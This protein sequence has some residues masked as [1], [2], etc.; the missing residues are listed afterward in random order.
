MSLNLTLLL[1][2]GVLYSVGI[3]LV[4]ER[5]L[6]RVLLGIMLLTNGTNLL[7]LHAG[8]LPGRSPLYDSGLDPRAYSDPLPQALVLTAIVI[9]FGLTAF[10]LGMIYRSWVLSHRD[11]ITD[12][13]ED[14]RVATQSSYDEELDADVAE[15][16]SDFDDEDIDKHEKE[17]AEEL[18]RH[19]REQENSDRR[20]SRKESQR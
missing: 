4:L 15:Q 19:R 8:G 5:S 3:Y 16:D 9:G 12:D 20:R 6:T 13:A 11:E 10:L 7:L 1:V 14:R 18:A 2:M 17:R